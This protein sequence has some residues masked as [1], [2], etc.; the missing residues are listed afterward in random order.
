MVG[1]DRRW[2]YEGWRMNHP[3]TEW[4]KKIEDFI[5]RAFALSRTGTDVRCPCSMCRVFRCQDKRT[6]SRHLCKY[7][8]MPDYEVWV[9]HGEEFPH[10]NVSEAHNN[11]EVEY[12]RMDEMLQDLREDPDFVFPPHPKEPPP[13]VKK[14]FD[15]LKVAE[16][17]LHEHIKVSILAFVTQLMAIMS[18]FVFSNNC[19]NELL[20]LISEVFPP[21]HKMLKDMYQCRKLLSGLGMDYQKIDVCPDNCMLF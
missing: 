11:D 4:I 1:E 19:Y 8:Y 9:Y 2:M 5:D 3:S 7:D 20:I 21:N 12:D 6:L 15:L 14:F 16:E 10:E 18:K 13:D 17:S